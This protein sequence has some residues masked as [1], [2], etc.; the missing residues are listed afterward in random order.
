[1]FSNNYPQK[2]K[3]S[4]PVIRTVLLYA[5]HIGLFLSGTSLLHAQEYNSTPSVAVEDLVEKIAQE[6]EENLDYHTLFSDIYNY[7]E[8]PLNLNTAGREELEKL[9]MLNDFQ[10]ASLQKY[11]EENGALLTIYELPLVYGFNESIAR[12]IEPL[13]V[14]EP[15]ARSPPPGKRKSSHQLLMRVSSVVEE[16]KGYS[17][18]SDS[19]L[20]A[21]PNARYL[22]NKLRIMTKYRY[23]WGNKLLIGYNGDKDA[24][25]PFF[26]GENKKGFDFNSVYFQIND[27]WKFKTLLVGDY[28]VRTGQGLSLWSGLAFGKSP[29]I[30]NIRKKGNAL[31]HYTSTDENRFMR[32]A[33]ATMELGN[34]D[35]TGFFSQ[36]N[37]DANMVEDTLSG[38]PMFSSFQSTGYHRTPSE[39]ADK[40]AVRETIAGG[41]VSWNHK[42]L[43]LGTTL[44]H[45]YYDSEYNKNPSG[46][47]FPGF[48]GNSNT[49]INLDYKLSLNRMIFFGETAFS[50]H[51]NK[52]AVLNG[53]SFDIHPQVSLSVLHRYFNKEFYALYGNGFRE[54][55]R[56]SNENGLYMGLE[57]Q[58]IPHWR[59][60]GY[61]DAYRF[62][63]L[64][65][66]FASNNTGFDYH[67]QADYA[68][69]DRLSGYLRFRFKTRPDNIN[70]EYTFSSAPITARSSQLRFHIS[71]LV[72]EAITFQNRLELSNY[73]KESKESGWL[74][75]HDIIYKPSSFPLS[76]SFRYAM[77]DTKSYASRIYTYEHDVLYAFSIPSYFGRGIRTYLNARWTVSRHIDLWLKYALSWYPDRETIGSGLNEILGHHKQ[78]IIAQLRLKF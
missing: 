9:H 15:P 78:D 73:E 43:N 59:I 51:S 24:G 29:D 39:S 32:G 50:A 28:Q 72:S 22:G 14:L 71:Y 31:K 74:A 36:K 23:K 75:Y 1:M 70:G 44:L 61:L 8:S 11:I 52:I 77:F 6:S 2:H 13:V 21:N 53:A 38:D 25:E 30:V 19:A 58:P 60:S 65:E 16:Q 47:Y 62:P 40:D 26:S 12:T 57:V 10:I 64:A 7:L 27:V 20:A 3:D 56:N 46:T 42:R 66:L 37:I 63:L 69:R 18:I 33:S 76:F 5:A 68:D 41:N 34:F 67:L 17:E 49:N 4:I 54:N 48:T 45:Y 35:I 55:S